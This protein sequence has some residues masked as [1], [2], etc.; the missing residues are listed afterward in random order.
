[1][2]AEMLPYEKELIAG[3][4]RRA[5]RLSCKRLALGGSSTQV[6]LLSRR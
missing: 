1:M 6:A 2:D 5:V 3:R 4:W